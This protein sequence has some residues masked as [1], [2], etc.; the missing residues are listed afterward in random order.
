MIR[1]IRWCL[2]PLALLIL[3]PVFLLAQGTLADYQRAESFFPGNL[4]HRVTIA[5]V[6]P[7]WI[8]KS[9]RFWYQQVSPKGVAYIVVDPEKNTSGPAF[10]QERLAAALSKAARREYQ[11]FR[12]PFFS[13]EYAKD[14]SA[15]QFQIEDQRWSCTLADY[16]CKSGGAAEPG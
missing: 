3:L 6:Q 15:I 16:K 4:W 13:F 1:N 9:D 11:A 7:H 2:A 8:G 14:G 10:D 12:L 5:N